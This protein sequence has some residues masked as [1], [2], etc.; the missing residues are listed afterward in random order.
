MTA[1]ASM[2][3][4]PQR[5]PRSSTL[6]RRAHLRV[7][8][9]RLGWACDARLVARMTTGLYVM[10]ID[11]VF[12]VVDALG[13]AGV[14]AWIAGGWGVDAL[15][16][17][18]TRR[19][20]DLDVVVDDTP[21]AVD[22]SRRALTGIG[23]RVAARRPASGLMPGRVVFADASGRSVDLLAVSTGY[24]TFGASRD[25]RS[26]FVV[27]ALDGRP[28]GCLSLALQL[29]LHDGIPL[30]PA[31]RADVA[32]LRRYLAGRD[33]VRRRARTRVPE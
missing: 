6:L 32:A 14:G 10:R 26:P 28:V 15:L 3:D 8:R 22:A 27:G 4:G 2:F 29:R 30:S 20:T 21:G 18:Q 24:G 7:V 9:S 33:A 5:W 17:R 1:Y 23:L 12:A 19:H 16:G 31:A 13:G 25:G 11:D